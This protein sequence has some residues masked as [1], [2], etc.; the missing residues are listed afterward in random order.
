MPYVDITSYIH[1]AGRET[2]FYLFFDLA[3][4]GFSAIPSE[5]NDDA[6][7]QSL[8]YTHCSDARSKT[9]STPTDAVNS[10]LARKSSD[11]YPT[12]IVRFTGEAIVTLLL[13][14]L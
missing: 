7:I 13:L 9:G 4:T 5:E 2:F 11:Y 12:F 8:R 6:C 10:S 14:L 3:I 1:L